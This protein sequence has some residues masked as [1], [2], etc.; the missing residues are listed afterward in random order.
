MA[1]PKIGNLA[2][3]L[4]LKNQAGETVSLK[5]FR[6]KANVL[7]YFYPRASTPG[8]TV[9][10]AAIRD[11]QADFKKQN[12]VVLGVSPDAGQRLQNFI[13]KQGLNFDLLSDEDSKITQKYGAWGEK[14]STGKEGLI[15]T[16][17]LIGKDGRLKAILDKFKTTDHHLQVLELLLELNK[18]GGV[19]TKN[20]APSKSLVKPKVGDM[21]KA[22]PRI[23]PVVGNMAP[24]FCLNNQRGEAVSLKDFRGKKNVLLYFYPKAL[25]PGCTNQAGGLRDHK[26]DLD[27]L[28]TVVLGISPD[29]EKRLQKFIDK[30]ELNFD[31]LADEDHALA[32]QYGC[33]GMKQFMGRHFMGLIRTSFIIGK[34]GRLKIIL[35]KFKTK[36]HHQDVLTALAKMQ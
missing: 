36:S 16:S 33:W 29:S 17:Y 31:L 23:L 15:R 32:D 24:T 19:S 13:G 4:S 34:D 8:C 18:S 20:V 11:H 7:L 3:A 12:C 35:D 14:K 6:G 21:A 9:Q 26:Q 22:E 1:Y 30:E 28:D 25:T 5:D 2:P 10:A 27:K